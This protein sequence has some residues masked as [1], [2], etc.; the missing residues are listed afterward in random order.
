MLPYKNSMDALSRIAC[1]SQLNHPVSTDKI[2]LVCYDEVINNNMSVELSCK[3]LFH[4]MCIQSVLK[5]SS[6]KKKYCP[7]CRLQ[8]KENTQTVGSSQHTTLQN[9]KWD[10][11]R[12]SDESVPVFVEG[13]SKYSGC[14]GIIQ[15]PKKDV[16]LVRVM[17]KFDEFGWSRMIHKNFLFSYL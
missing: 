5:L 16:H 2:C 3:H 13:A 8:I 9:V 6:N 4:T 17:V 12:Q 10:E 15:N 1:V 14:Y 7:Y 11:I